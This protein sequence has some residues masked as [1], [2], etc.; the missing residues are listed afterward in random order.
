MKAKV[1]DGWP[2]ENAIRI[3]LSDTDSAQEN[4]IRR[5]L[6]SDVPKLAIIRV[7]ITKEVVKQLDFNKCIAIIIPTRCCWYIDSYRDD[8]LFLLFLFILLLFILLDPDIKS[9]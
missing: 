7:N 4:A 2:R 5:A 1:V 9:F 3:I 8:M 6:I